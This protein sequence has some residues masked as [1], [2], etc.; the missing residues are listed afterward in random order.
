MTVRVSIVLL[1]HNGASTLPEVLEAVAAQRCEHQ[2]E[3]VAV[4][5]GSTDGTLS[6]LEGRVD[7][8][9]RIAPEEFDH[10]LTRNL[11]IDASAGDLIVLL[12]QDAVPAGHDWL[13]ALTAPLGADPQVAG[14]FAR[15]Q[16]RHDA[17]AITRHYF[18]RWAGASPHPR[19]EELSDQADLDQLAPQARLD[20]CTFDNVCSCIRRSVWQQH[21]FRST[22]IGEDIEWA[23][24]VLLAGYRLTYVPGAVVTHSHDRPASYEFA[25]TYA[26]HRRLHDLF[27]LRTIPSIPLLVRAVLSSVVLHTRCQ[28]QE[29][30]RR[31][32][33]T[34]ALAL[35]VAWPF[36]QYLGALS[37]ARKWKPLRLRKV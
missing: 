16:P 27:G 25:R 17:T 33:Y 29:Q 24:E 31:T 12:V 22:P 2:V 35:A 3:V 13:A 18:D 9:V 37:A 7:R 4:D 32:S 36:G 10:G 30:G 14:T 34:R 19:T 1:T 8:L 20:R 28:R 11:G 26:L 6:L 23:K 21:P 5:S 15:Q